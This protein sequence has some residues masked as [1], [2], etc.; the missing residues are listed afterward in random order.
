MRKFC[1]GNTKTCATLYVVLEQTPP[2]AGSTRSGTTVRC[3]SVRTSSFGR[4]I[5]RGVRQ[6][7]VGFKLW[8]HAAE[9]QHCSGTCRSM[10]P[11]GRQ[12]SRPRSHTSAFPRWTAMQRMRCSSATQCRFLCLCVNTATD[13]N[14]TVKETSARTRRQTAPCRSP[15]PARWTA[16]PRCRP[17]AA[18]AWRAMA[19][20][21]APARAGACL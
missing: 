3:R 14:S 19:R 11:A 21:S 1:A 9:G 18:R 10:R 17:V 12:Q 15:K 2:C 20:H 16:P 5:R 4:R 7:W 13:S 8:V 6:L